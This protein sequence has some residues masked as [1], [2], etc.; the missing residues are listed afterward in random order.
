MTKRTV[1]EIKAAKT[2]RKMVIKIGY[3]DFAC[4]ARDAITLLDAAA[5]MMKVRQ[6]HSDDYRASIWVPS[7]DQEPAL[8][9]AQ[10]GDVEVP[11]RDTLASD[12]FINATRS[13]S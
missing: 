3:E 8:K 9:E 5:R 1:E 6:E 12:I 7:E 2:I 10:L 11:E 13:V 4:D